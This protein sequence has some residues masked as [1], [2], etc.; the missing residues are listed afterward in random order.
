MK[1]FE[2]LFKPKSAK[3]EPALEQAAEEVRIEAEP[4]VEESPE[5][6][7]SLAEKAELMAVKKEELEELQKERLNYYNEAKSF[8]DKMN[9]LGLSDEKKKEIREQIMAEGGEIS[10]KIQ[11]IREEYGFSPSPVEV[12]STRFKMID[13]E[14]N[15]IKEDPSMK[16]N[17]LKVV[18]E[19]RNAF[20]EDHMLKGGLANFNNNMKYLVEQFNDVPEF[21]ALNDKFV[22][23]QRVSEDKDGSA[24]MKKFLEFIKEFKVEVEERIS[25]GNYPSP[26]EREKAGLKVFRLQR[27]LGEIDSE[28]Y[29]AKK[30]SGRFAEAESSGNVFKGTF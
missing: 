21:V 10:A 27:I 12:Y 30:K 14:I 24:L 4:E 22:E 26:G 23:Y 18:L 5:Q 20:D 3:E 9:S 1:F 8:E 25:E 17:K 19:A 11:A 13:N 15:R 16:Y 6:K 28:L 29:D 2:K 7:L